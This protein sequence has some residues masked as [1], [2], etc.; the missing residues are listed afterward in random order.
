MLEVGCG[1]GVLGILCA[2]L[3][4][5]SVT[6][7]DVSS[8]A[9]A[10]AERNADRNG[11]QVG[12]SVADWATVDTGDSDILVAAEVL[13]YT[14]AAPELAKALRRIP[15]YVIAHVP[16]YTVYRDRNT[17]EIVQETDDSALR[18]LQAELPALKVTPWREAPSAI[19][20]LTGGEQVLPHVDDRAPEDER[21]VTTT[22]V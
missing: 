14:R 18:A 13:Y 9:V 11:V 6:V 3:G 7:S 5:A 15:R 8:T 19:Y 1:L 2:R 4:A 22:N 10:A 20:L 21:A 17:G 16:R 12:T